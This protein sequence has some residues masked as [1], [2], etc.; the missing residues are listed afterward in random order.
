MKIVIVTSF[1]F[2]ILA[3]DPSSSSSARASSASAAPST[4]KESSKPITPTP[5]EVKKL[6]TSSPVGRS[7]TSHGQEQAPLAL[8]AVV[9]AF[10]NG[11]YSF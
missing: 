3:I 8:A 5:A 6:A 7:T 9:L 1:V 11:I 2:A 10:S 4:T